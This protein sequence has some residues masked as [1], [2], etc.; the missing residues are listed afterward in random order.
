MA[1]ALLQVLEMKLFDFGTSLLGTKSNT[2]IYQW[3]RGIRSAQ[4]RGFLQMVLWQ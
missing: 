2:R 1:K 4:D 3:R